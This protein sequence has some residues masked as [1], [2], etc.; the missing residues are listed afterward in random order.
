MKALLL[1]PF[2]ALVSCKKKEA[3]SHDEAF[4]QVEASSYVYSLSRHKANK[5]NAT[6][7]EASDYEEAKSLL[8]AAEGKA[9]DSGLSNDDVNRAK[10]LG[11]SNAAKDIG[12]K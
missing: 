12:P 5:A 9:K 2:L 6:P 3:W 4:K 10:E 7:V 11:A 1:I 8:E